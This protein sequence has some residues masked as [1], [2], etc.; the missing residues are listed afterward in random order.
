MKN[1]L[2]TLKCILSS[3]CSQT[4]AH[5]LR[6]SRSDSSREMVQDWLHSREWEGERVCDVLGCEWGSQQGRDEL[7]ADVQ[8]S[9]GGLMLNQL[10][11]PD[12]RD[13]ESDTSSQLPIKTC[14]VFT[15]N[16]TIALYRW[17]LGCGR[18]A[19]MGVNTRVLGND[20][21]ENKIMCNW[22]KQGK[23]QKQKTN[24]LTFAT[25]IIE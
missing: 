25:Q 24:P 2:E 20:S 15:N 9:A 19:G 1:T 11:S 21:N 8:E 3:C 22:K 5:P 18:D 7:S 23:K 13:T 10:S 16:I 4:W 17:T 6:L 12:H 14:S